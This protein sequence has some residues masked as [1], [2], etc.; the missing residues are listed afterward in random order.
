MK[1]VP[2]DIISVTDA[3]IGPAIR[4]GS[5]PILFATIGSIDPISLAMTTI[6]VIDRHTVIATPGGL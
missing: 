4:A 1:Y 2:S 5:M 3:I 6:T